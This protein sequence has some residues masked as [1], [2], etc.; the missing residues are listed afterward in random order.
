MAYCPNCGNFVAEGDKFCGTC[1]TSASPAQTTNAASQENVQPINAQN[2][3]Q[4]GQP[5]YQQNFQQGGQ[6]NFQQNFQQNPQY[7]FGPAYNQQ[8]VKRTPSAFGI[9]MGQLGKELLS[10]LKHPIETI[11]KEKFEFSSI[12]TYFLAVVITLLIVLQNFWSAAKFKNA[13]EAISGFGFDMNDIQQLLGITRN[14]GTKELGNGKLFLTSLLFVII[15][16]AAIWAIS[17]LLNSVILK[18]KFTPLHALKVVALIAV[19]YFVTALLGTIL[20][21][22]DANLGHMV[23]LAGV[24]ASLILLYK[25]LGSNIAKSESVMF[26]SFIA[27]VIA[28]Y[29]VNFLIFKVAGASIAVYYHGIFIGLQ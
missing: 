16:L 6:P 14:G 27:V 4:N 20:S 13:S 10:F 26:Y 24:I 19:P 11:T 8:F 7:N 25:A 17:L 23:Y 1:G 2:F 22:A 5:Q 15:M 9:A 28:L 29:F 12:A 3:Q 21:Y 18:G